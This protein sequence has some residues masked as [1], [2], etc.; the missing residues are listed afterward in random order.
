MKQEADVS[1][2]YWL[3]VTNVEFCETYNRQKVMTV[4]RGC[5]AGVWELRLVLAPSDN[6]KMAQMLWVN[7]QR[8]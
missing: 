1:V 3:V 7:W 8:K 4:R 5:G 6:E 2:S